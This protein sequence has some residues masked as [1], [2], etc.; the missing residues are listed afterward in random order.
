ME[1]ITPATVILVSGGARGITAH[2]V[3]ALARQFRCK[4][5]LLGRTPL[6][7]DPVWAQGIVDES[8]L[9]R[10]ALTDAQ[11]RGE[12]VTPAQIGKTANA[13][14]AQREIRATLDAV[15]KVSGEALY[16]NADIT[17]PVALREKL[18]TVASFGP[19]TGILHGAGNLADKLIENK[20]PAD[21]ENV[22]AAKVTGLEN[23][24]AA[25]SADALRNLIL[26][27]SVA[28]FYGNI[29]QA[30]Y[31]IA[32]EVLNKTAYRFKKLHPNCRVISINW[33]PW[34][35]G[36]VTP[37]LREYFDNLNIKVIPVE[38][39][40]QL[41]VDE[42][43][44]P[45]DSPVQIVIG[46]AIRPQPVAPSG[47]LNTYALRRILRLAESPFLADH[48]VNNR[49]V[50]PM[51]AGMSWMTNACEGLYRGYHFFSFDNYRVLKGII[52]DE[53][54]ADDYTL[55]LKE[56]SKSAYEIVIDAL[57]RSHSPE[58]K[59]R[60]HYSA[61]IVLRAQIPA[62]PILQM[63]AIPALTQAIPGSQ[64]YQDGTLFH[65]VSF[66]GVDQVL[67]L[68]EAGVVMRC[69]IPKVSDDYQGQFPIQA[70]NYYM[71]D[72]GL[73]SIGIWSRHFYKMG[74]LPLRAG[75]GQ[76]YRHGVMGQSFFV[77]MKVRAHSQTNVSASITLH[78]EEGH[79][80]LSI[81]DLEVTMSLRLN[82]LFLKNQ[83]VEA[84]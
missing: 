40:T 36:M 82:D 14:I 69:I 35:G 39:G 68:N 6:Q 67:E 62:V 16:L 26:F 56:V 53:T 44:A 52:F 24:L 30:D 78:D 63:S 76:H 50:L 29:G 25:I 45:S 13:I 46:S 66:Q 84:L 27:S 77:T 22:Y 10:R 19:I 3:I 37:Q 23:L 15:Q 54:L 80:Y 48:V 17:D 74:S 64:F 5:I 73:Q 42:L 12:K 83:L 72:I 21:F 81:D 28:G 43:N 11:S 2:C 49:A 8:D 58:G 7:E 32:N 61:Q 18:M 20:T 31:A 51:V 38:V 34:D 4:F 59:P 75:Q 33:G 79:I 1:K 60:F 55:E 41:L 65:G 70:F 47:D 57:V 71:A 9:K